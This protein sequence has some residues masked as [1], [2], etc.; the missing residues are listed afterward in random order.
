MPSGSTFESAMT[1]V[2]KNSPVVSPKKLNF[3]AATAE[4]KKKDLDIDKC[5]LAKFKPMK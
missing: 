1:P 3:A 5:E 4:K 2:K